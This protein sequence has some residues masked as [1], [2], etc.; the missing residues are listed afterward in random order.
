M[1]ELKPGPPKRQS[2]PLPAQAGLT[3]SRNFHIGHLLWP[4]RW[5]PFGDTQG[6]RNGN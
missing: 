6:N 3:S 5:A 1:A 2:R 4:M